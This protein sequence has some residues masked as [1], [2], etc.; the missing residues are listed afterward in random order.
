MGKRV[1]YR[2]VDCG[3]EVAFTTGGAGSAYHEETEKLEKE[4]RDET[5]RGKYG[6]LLRRI[7]MAD[8]DGELYYDC[9]DAVFQCLDCRRMR[10]HRRRRIVNLEPS[11]R[12][13][14]LDINVRQKC[15]D[16]GSGFFG[17]VI[18]RSRPVCPKC[19]DGSMKLVEE[20]KK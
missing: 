7:A 2:C 6:P 12:Q 8:D 9:S 4:F 1:R 5:L 18:P 3:F 11:R 16:C 13:Y 14:G 15:P 17:E 10:V 19:G 20:D